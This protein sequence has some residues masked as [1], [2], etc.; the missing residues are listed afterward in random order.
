MAMSLHQLSAIASSGDDRPVLMLNLNLY[1]R[2]AAYPDGELYTRH[3]SGLEA[4]LPSVGGSILW[5]FPA[6]GQPVGEQRLDEIL[7]AWYPSHQALLDLRSAPGSEENYR[8][9]AFAI[10]HAVIHRCPGNQ[11]AFHPGPILVN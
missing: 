8:L 1:S 7:A 9:R 3:M 11:T 4:F 6:L 5:R 2:E 10:E